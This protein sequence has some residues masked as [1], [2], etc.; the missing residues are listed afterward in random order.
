MIE[1]AISQ[2]VYMLVLILSTIVTL[3]VFQL[4][5]KYQIEAEEPEVAPAVVQANTIQADITSSG[6][7]DNSGLKIYY[8]DI[9]YDGGEIEGNHVIFF[10]NHL[11]RARMFVA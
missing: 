2:L 4:F 9:G 3:I 1:E 6:G 8:M 11:L 10:H 5:M 7:D